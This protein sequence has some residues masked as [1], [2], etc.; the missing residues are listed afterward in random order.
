[1][2]KPIPVRA[3]TPCPRKSRASP[4]TSRKS[5]PALASLTSSSLISRIPC[6][7][8]TPKFPALARQLRRQASLLPL[9]RRALQDPLAPPVPWP[10]RLASQPAHPRPTRFIP[11]ASATSPAANTISPAPNLRTTSNSE[12]AR[13]SEEHTSELQSPVHLVCRLLL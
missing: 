2:F 7:L 11:T 3:W 8:S 4:T 5:N 10:V 6:K 9:L 13:R 1:M 12:R